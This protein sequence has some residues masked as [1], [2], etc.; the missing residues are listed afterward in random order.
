MSHPAATPATVNAVQTQNTKLAAS[1]IGLGFP[2]ELDWLHDVSPK[3]KEGKSVLEFRFQQRSLRPEFAAMS[4]AIA[5]DWEC[6]ALEKADAMHPLCVAM[7]AQHNYDRIIGMHRGE[8][9]NL[10]ST[11]WLGEEKLH[12]PRMT[13]YLKFTQFDPVTNFSPVRVPETD[14]ALVASLAG[15]GLP[16]IAMDGAEGSRRY[17]L[18]EHGYTLYKDDGSTYL[19]S[20][21]ELIRRA[22][23]AKDPRRLALEDTAPLHPVCLA[24]DALNARA[25]LK[26]VL[27]RRN[28]NLHIRH[29]SMEVII[30]S[31]HSP[32]IMDVIAKKIGAPVLTGW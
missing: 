14:L 26:K 19:A 9:M 31:N 13:V 7:R 4:P 21:S 23:T 2:V 8:V 27:E 17:W 18:P 6:G 1:L 29:G 11:A 24:Y 22:P 16:V 15:V 3:G 5:K 12:R 28:A 20:A 10:R 32:R 30:G 25:L